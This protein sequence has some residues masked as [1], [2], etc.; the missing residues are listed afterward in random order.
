MIN[1]HFATVLGVFIV[2][3]ALAAPAIAAEAAPDPN[4]QREFG[5]RLQ[6]CSACH[7]AN[8]VP[9]NG[10]IPI[11]YG[12]QEDYLAK[13][14]HDFVTGDRAVEVMAWMSKSLEPEQLAP[15]SVFFAKKT[16]PAHPTAAA[17]ATPP[18]GITVCQ[19]CHNT[20]FRGARQAEGMVTPRLAGQNYE[21]LVEAMRRFA[22]GERTNNSDMVQ[23]MKA[24]TPAQRETM[25]RYLAGL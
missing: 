5:A 20:D 2:V 1:N 12:Q 7:G 18:A 15:T 11:I 3:G 10:T 14:L 17:A 23:I 4:V 6:V 24:I 19:A 21:Y 9:K 13:Q 22:D 25:A 16:W 8:G